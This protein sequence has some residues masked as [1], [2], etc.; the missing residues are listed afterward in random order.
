MASFD[1]P[2]RFGD[3]AARPLAAG[4]L[5]IYLPPRAVIGVALRCQVGAELYVG[6]NY[7]IAMVFVTPLA[8]LM[9]QL[10]APSDPA[11]LLRDRIVDTVIGV[12]IGTLIAIGSAFLRRT[13]PAPPA[14]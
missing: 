4:R 11:L 7:G 13:H 8:L 10:A 9:V 6:R 14:P 2:A 5:A 12:T 1:D 3:A